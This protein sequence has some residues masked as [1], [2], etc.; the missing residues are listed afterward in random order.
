MHS[1]SP[2]G[3]IDR[4]ERFLAVSVVVVAVVSA[5][6]VGQVMLDGAVVPGCVQIRMR[7]GHRP[8]SRRRSRAASG[9]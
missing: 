1:G 5:V 9:P 7:G 4:P 8:H 3:D 2:R 6:V